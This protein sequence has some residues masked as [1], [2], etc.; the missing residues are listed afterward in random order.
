MGSGD[1]VFDVSGAEVL[2]SQVKHADVRVLPGIGHLPMIEAPKETSQAY[3]GS[4]RKSVG[5]QT[6]CFGNLI[7]SKAFFL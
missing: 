6:L 5:S 2:K 7:R 3:T 4:L 1:L